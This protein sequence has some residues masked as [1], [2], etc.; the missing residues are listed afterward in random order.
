MTNQLTYKNF[1][2]SIVLQG[3]HGRDVLFLGKRFFHTIRRKYESDA[4]SAQQ[5]AI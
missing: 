2:L 5:M 3:V 1:D 4:G